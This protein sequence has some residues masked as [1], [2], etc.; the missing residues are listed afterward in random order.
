MGFF[1]AVVFLVVLDWV[2]WGFFFSVNVHTY[3]G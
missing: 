1:F 3:P 2:V